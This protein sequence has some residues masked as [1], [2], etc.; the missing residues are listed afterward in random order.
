[1]LGETLLLTLMGAMIG[2][3]CALAA[4]QLAS[5]LLFVVSAG[6]LVTLAIVLSILLGTGAIAG[7]LPSRRAMRLDPLTALRDE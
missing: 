1:M 7:Y 5:R 2:L 6:G 3:P 4:A